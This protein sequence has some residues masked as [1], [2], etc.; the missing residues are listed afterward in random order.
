MPA[1]V[2][3]LLAL[4]VAAG[5]PAP[6][7]REGQLSLERARALY[8]AHDDSGESVRAA[9]A[10]FRRA[11]QLNPR[12]AAA[13]A[14]LGFIAADRDKP[15]EAEAEYREALKIDPNCAEAHVGLG[16][17]DLERGKRTEAL[18][19]YRQAVSG[20]PGNALARRVLAEAL[21]YSGGPH[22]EAERLEAIGCWQALIRLDRNDRQAHHEL[23]RAYQELSRWA[24][25]EREFREVLRIGQLPDDTVVWVYQVH[26]D[27]A[28]VLEKQGKFADAI[29]EYRALIGSR[30]AGEDEIQAA[31]AR[32]EALRRA[33]RAK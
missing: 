4:L 30:G 13:A 20:D 22:N 10:E 32:I 6:Q 23:G 17:L 31:K 9:E 3:A 26:S 14:Y 12:L 21:T 15:D 16:R 29:R 24:E 8:E 19:E 33:K 7:N 1:V 11:L 2:A 18:A 28:A 25:S 27:L 5:T